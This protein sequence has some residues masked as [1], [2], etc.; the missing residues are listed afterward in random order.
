M[1]EMNPLEKQLQSW[2]PR[3]PSAKI[4]RRLFAKAEQA[5]RFLRRAEV[6]SWLTPVAA[7]VLTLL[8][9]VHS[10]DCRLPRL[11]A[12]DNTSFF[13]TLMFNA[14]TSNGPQ[15]FVLSKMDENV[16]WNVWPHAFQAVMPTNH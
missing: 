11:S 1:Q 6:W 9:A 2:T 3:R 10:A 8:V 15:T 14:A 12:Q 5:P 7:C 16:E 13:A 4:A